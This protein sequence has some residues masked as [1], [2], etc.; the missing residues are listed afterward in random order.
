MN[1]QQN[2]QSSQEKRLG[3]IESKLD[4][5]LIL[6][7]MLTTA[8]NFSYD[9]SNLSPLW[10]RA[11]SFAEGLASSVS[12]SVAM[13]HPECPA[14]HLANVLLGMGRLPNGKGAGLEPREVCP[15]A[16]ED[17]TVSQCIPSLTSH[18]TG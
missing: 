13:A 8:D 9:M 10:I 15:V 7:A 17:E 11:M 12:I 14:E 3:D 2:E 5:C 16:V 4:S 1:D 18:Q 6:L